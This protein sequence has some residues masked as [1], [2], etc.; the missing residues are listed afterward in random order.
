MSNMNDRCLGVLI[1]A[2]LGSVAFG[3][4]S[5]IYNDLPQEGMAYDLLLSQP[6]NTSWTDSLK[7]SA[8]LADIFY[9][10]SGLGGQSPSVF[11]STQMTRYY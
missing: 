3:T 1:I 7:I 10:T 5:D 6:V 8:S 9:D 4:L 11:T 2:I